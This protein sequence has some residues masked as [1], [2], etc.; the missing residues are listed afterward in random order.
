MKKN[1]AYGL[2]GMNLDGFDLEK[3]ADSNILLALQRVLSQATHEDK[4]GP[5]FSSW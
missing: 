5:S 1:P 3:R 2:T 4:R